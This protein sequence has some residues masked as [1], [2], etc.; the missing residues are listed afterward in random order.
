MD[1]FRNE[2]LLAWALEEIRLYRLSGRGPSVAKQSEQE[3]QSHPSTGASPIGAGSSSQ[4]CSELVGS[5]ETGSPGVPGD[6]PSSSFLAPGAD[7]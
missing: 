5:G 6:Q 7:R 3:A 2:E 1:P 4:A